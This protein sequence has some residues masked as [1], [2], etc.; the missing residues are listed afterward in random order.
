[1]SNI[2]NFKLKAAFAESLT[3]AKTGATLADKIQI[4]LDALNTFIAGELPAGLKRSIKL[5]LAASP[6]NTSTREVR[7]TDPF[8]PHEDGQ[9]RCIATATNLQNGKYDLWTCDSEIC[10]AQENLTDE[11]ILSSLGNAL[12]DA[13]SE[14]EIPTPA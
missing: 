13:V 9:D 4:T 12:S 7:I 3:A 8:A 5:Q 6:A 1:M 2:D 11:E 14:I 10:E